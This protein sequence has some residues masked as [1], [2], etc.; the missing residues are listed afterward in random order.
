MLERKFLC[1][2]VEIPM[3]LMRGVR[4]GICIA[5][6][7]FV[8][9]HVYFHW[10]YTRYPKLWSKYVVK[11]TNAVQ[12]FWQGVEPIYVACNS[13]AHAC[14]FAGGKRGLCSCKRVQWLIYKV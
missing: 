12:D 5:E 4:R 9:P 14:I 2:L 1:H 3:K 8:M 6:C 10:L 13:V 7:G 11:D